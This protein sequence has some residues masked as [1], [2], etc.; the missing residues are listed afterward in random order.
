MPELHPP[1]LLHRPF[2]PLRLV[3][4]RLELSAVPA[5]AFFDPDDFMLLSWARPDRPPHVE[6]FKHIDT[7]RCLYLDRDGTAH[8][9]DDEGGAW[10]VATLREAVDGLGLWELPWLRPDLAAHRRGRTWDERWDLYEELTG[11]GLPEAS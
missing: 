5:D 2:A 10:R 11:D 3:A 4:T 9:H 1:D 7:R 8:R 6:V